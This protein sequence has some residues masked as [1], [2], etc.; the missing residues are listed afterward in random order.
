MSDFATKKKVVSFSQ[1]SNYF[2]CANRWYLDYV[3]DLKKFEDSLNMSFGT[4]IHEA[5]QFFILTL[6]KPKEG[7]GNDM[8]W[9]Q[10]CEIAAEK[11]DLVATFQKSFTEE[12]TKKNIPHTP[13]EF[14]EFIEDGKAIL[15]TFKDAT[16]RIKFFPSHKYELIDIE[17]ELRMPIRNGVDIVAYLDIV[18]KEKATGRIKIIDIKT[19]TRGW[20][21]Y[22]MEDFSKTAQLVLY[23]ALYS[24]KHN[25]PLSKIDVEFFIVKR[26]L[27]CQTQV[28]RKQHVHTESHSDFPSAICARQ[29][30]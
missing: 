17:H 8:E 18:L 30:P 6:Y 12:V 25:V 22:Q 23:K 28:A 5:M 29:C 16:N 11:L 14:A 20:F 9:C 13:E 27:Y 21:N 7:T 19:A 10:R 15:A 1:F 24:K 3:K 2:A 26:V 4:G